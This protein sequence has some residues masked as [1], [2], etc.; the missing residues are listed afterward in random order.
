LPKYVS[1]LFACTG[2]VAT[3]VGLGLMLVGQ[4]LNVAAMN[5]IGKAGIY[6]GCKLGHKVPQKY[7]A[8]ILVFEWSALMHV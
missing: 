4:W 2:V 7:D 3:L 5:A 6:Y 1:L 8:F